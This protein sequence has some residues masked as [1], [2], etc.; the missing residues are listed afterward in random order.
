MLSSL[1]GS[2][3][4][5]RER[6]R[7]NKPCMC[8]LG[9]SP[10]DV[11]CEPTVMLALTSFLILVTRVPARK[12]TTR[13]ANG[14]FQGCTACAMAEAAAAAIPAGVRLL[15]ECARYTKA[16]VAGT[17]MMAFMVAWD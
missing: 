13:S 3:C 8:V 4:G 5:L 14:R 12:K 15:W 17:A 9:P 6:E 2:E 7:F 11:P 1:H 16:S 10:P